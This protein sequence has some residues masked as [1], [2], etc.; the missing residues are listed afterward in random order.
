ML[1][2]SPGAAEA[3]RSDILFGRCFQEERPLGPNAEVY[4]GRQE[5]G[6][7]AGVVK[8]HRSQ[9]DRDWGRELETDRT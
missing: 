9:S 4:R 1:Q 3:Q 5:R 8:V 7:L 6:L 2:F